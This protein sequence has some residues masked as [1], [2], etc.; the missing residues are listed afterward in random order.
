LASTLRRLLVDN[1]SLLGTVPDALGRM[2]SLNVF[3]L[4]GNDFSGS[5]PSS[6]C[7][8]VSD[9]GLQVLTADCSEVTCD[10]C[11]ECF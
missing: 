4:H 8:L 2:T 5:I 1:N 11:T 3:E 7:T 9:G 10:C 6:L